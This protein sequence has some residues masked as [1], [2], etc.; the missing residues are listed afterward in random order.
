MH[1][2]VMNSEIFYS[3]LLFPAEP[4]KGI[5][6][7]KG[8][9][10][11]IPSRILT[12]N[13]I[14]DTKEVDSTIREWKNEY[15]FH[16]GELQIA[17]DL[18][19]G[20]RP[21]FVN[22]RGTMNPRSDPN[23]RASIKDIFPHTKFEDKNYGMEGKFVASASAGFQQE[24]IFSSQFGSSIHSEVV[25]TFKYKPTI[26]VIESGAAGETFFW[27]F[28]KNGNQFPT[29]GLELKMI[30]E[31]PRKTKS[32]YVE[33][34]V[35]VSYKKKYMGHKTANIKDPTITDLAFTESIIP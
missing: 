27:N 29:G 5:H 28:R 24:E 34:N 18:D 1:Q 16:Y 15:D 20:Y 22:I 2:F 33:W 21:E 10:V 25:F 30:I 14:K 4:T 11:G 32:M 3:D 26:P 31:R 23:D 13:M 8:G 6:E 7:F 17:L 35:L 19:E 9:R 12:R